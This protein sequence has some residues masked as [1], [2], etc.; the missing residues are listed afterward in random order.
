[1]PGFQLPLLIALAL[2]MAGPGPAP[3]ETSSVASARMFH[4]TNW[5]EPLALHSAFRGELLL[6]LMGGPVY[7][8]Q[9][10]G[11]G[12]G[13]EPPAPT[14]VSTASP[15]PPRNLLGMVF[16]GSLAGKIVVGLILALSVLAVFSIVDQ[17]LAISRRRIL[18]RGVMDE[19]ERLV[20]HGELQRAMQLCREKDNYSMATELVLAGL[21]RYHNSEFGFAEYRTA[22]EEA[23]ED[24][25]GRLYR[26]TELLNVIGSIAPMLGLL[27]TVIGMIE[28]FTTIAAREG[29]ATPQELAGGI[30]DA[31]ITT[32]LGLV[33]AIPAMVALSFFRTRIDSLVAESGKRIERILA[34]LGRRRP[35][36][37]P[38]ETAQ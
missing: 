27:G 6:A 38:R 10:D 29:M 2:T 12:A 24:L 13:T 15:A 31:L 3:E 22:V 16:G 33:V 25:T 18:P 8:P 28:A 23:G 17:S 21:E 11:A 26:R 9:A 14:T 5:S 32:F 37:S 35:G 4:C 20:L 34:P 30:G 1:M 19:L 7:Q 36:N